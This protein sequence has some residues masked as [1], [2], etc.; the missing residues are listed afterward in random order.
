MAYMNRN[1]R[2][3][4]GDQHFIAL[5]HVHE[6][7]KSKTNHINTRVSTWS[8]AMNEAWYYLKSYL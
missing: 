1:T 6:L 3:V 4:S 8:T 2:M 5:M 7:V